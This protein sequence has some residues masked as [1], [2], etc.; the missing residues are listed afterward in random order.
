MLYHAPLRNL[1][2]AGQAMS[3]LTIEQKRAEEP[4]WFIATPPCSRRFPSLEEER[5]R[6]R[7]RFCLGADF[8]LEQRF[9][10]GVDWA[11][12]ASLAC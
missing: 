2:L 3:I 9:G 11:C 6:W 4:K 12:L 7:V 1:K 8:L 5:L 10:S